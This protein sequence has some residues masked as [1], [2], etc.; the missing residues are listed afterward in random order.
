M[1]QYPSRGSLS[2]AFRGRRILVTGA[3]GFIGSHLVAR[4]VREGA[5][6]H[7]FV[8]RG[9]SLAR[10]EPV[11]NSLRIWDGDIADATTIHEAITEARPDVVYHLA[12]DTGVRQLGNGWAGVDRSLRVNL[13][14]TLNVLRAT[15][16][17]AQPAAAFIRTGGLEEY[18]DGPTPATETQRE[19]PI[20]PY[21]ASQVAATQYCDMLQ[22]STETSIV[23][24]RPA[25]TFGPGQSTEFFIPSLIRHC[26]ANE[27]FLMTDGAQRRDLLYV[28]DLVDALRQC[29]TRARDVRGV[30]NIG[31]GVETTMREVAESIVRLSGTSA[32]LHVG[33][34][35]RRAEDLQHQVACVDRAGAVLDWTPRISLADGLRRTIDAERA[36]FGVAAPP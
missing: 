28:D 34:L 23:T 30:I 25:L 10:L 27:D 36:V 14:G 5:E 19:R 1:F 2:S 29:A 7:A 13:E 20:S 22:R 33:A 24:V 26:L 9:G 16:E 32:R 8:R 17:V 18:G 3:T 35:T 11:R 4:L 15:I 6:V 21:S 31:T 12:A